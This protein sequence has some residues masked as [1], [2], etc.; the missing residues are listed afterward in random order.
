MRYLTAEE[1]LFIHS[2]IIDET[3]GLHGVRDLGAIESAAARLKQTFGGQALYPSL[4]DKAAALFHSLIHFHPFLDGNKRTAI[5]AAGVFLEWNGFLITV[6]NRFLE[7]F[8]LKAAINHLD[9]DAIAI[10]FKKH[11]KSLSPSRF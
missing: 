6:S 1:I 7:D 3:G 2:A 10:W 9:I 5:A 11:T 4:F 8:T